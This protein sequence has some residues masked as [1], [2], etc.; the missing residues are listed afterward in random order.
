MG[1]ATNLASHLGGLLCSEIQVTDSEAFFAERA[2]LV[3]IDEPWFTIDLGVSTNTQL[4]VIAYLHEG[5]RGAA[6]RDPA[7]A[8]LSRAW[9]SPGR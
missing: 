2:L 6:F 9:P 4:G 7:A 3:R 8:A 5:H 1:A